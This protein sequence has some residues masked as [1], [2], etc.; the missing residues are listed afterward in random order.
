MGTILNKKTLIDTETGEIINEKK[1]LG[2]DGFDEKGYNYR[3]KAPS[4]KYF[5]DSL[6]CNLSPN[7]WNLL[8][9]IAEIMNDENVLVYRVPRKSKFCSIIYRPM[10]KD[11]I[12]QRLRFPWGM[13]KFN[14]TWTELS[15]HCIKKID[16][17]ND[18]Q[19]YAVN[20]AV[21]LKKNRIPYWLY[22]EF[23]DYMNPHLS[24][25]TIKK[26]QEKITYQD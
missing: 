22:E 8:M 26:L 18:L 11:D 21:I 19:V 1:W 10:N 2:Y 7:A 4:I 6:P 3:V 9:L 16:Y 24:A 12:R 13:N 17:Y 15:K 20:P 5:F 23:Q 25:T 14:T